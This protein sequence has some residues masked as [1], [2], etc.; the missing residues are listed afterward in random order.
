[1]ELIYMTDK[2]IMQLAL[3]ALEDYCELGTILRPIKCRDAL[4]ARIKQLNA[5]REEPCFGDERHYA[6]D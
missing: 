2:E 1:M 6:N 5:P 3:D 4:R